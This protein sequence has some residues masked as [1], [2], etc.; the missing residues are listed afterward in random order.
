L[1]PNVSDFL[2]NSQ[3]GKSGDNITTN[4]NTNSHNTTGTAYNGPISV[5]NNYGAGQQPR[6]N[7]LTTGLPKVN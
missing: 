7:T 2:P 3:S 1:L 5:T 6:G 4:Q